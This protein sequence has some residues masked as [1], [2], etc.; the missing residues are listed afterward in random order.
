MLK[1][2][3]R[4]SWDR[5][6]A[7]GIITKTDGETKQSIIIDLNQFDEDIQSKMFV[8][9]GSKIYDDRLSQI[10]AAVKMQSVG[11]LTEQFLGGKWK[12]DKTIGDR[13]MPPIIQVIMNAQGC[14]VSVAQ[15]AYKAL[16]EESRVVLKEAQAD[17]IAD[18]IAAREAQDIPSLDGMMSK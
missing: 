12:S 6:P 15:A 5:D 13:F 11:T 16:D 4:F 8:Y 14:T 18:V 2:K 17:A 3:Q 9:G 10:P 1:S 7:T